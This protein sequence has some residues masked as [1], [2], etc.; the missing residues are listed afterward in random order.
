MKIQLKRSN[1][2][3]AGSAKQPTA[4]QLEY[5]ELAVNYNNTDPAIFLK[6]SNNNIIRISGVG[7]IA[8]DGQVELPL[9]Q[10]LRLVLKTVTSGITQT[11][12]DYIFITMTAI[13][14]SG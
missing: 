13:L 4:S 6:D 9:L 10:H 14:H 1:V 2:L 7:N 5:G 3:D 8:D 12:V 11:K